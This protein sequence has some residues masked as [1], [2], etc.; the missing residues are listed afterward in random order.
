VEH[1]DEASIEQDAGAAEETL[2]NNQSQCA[3]RGGEEPAAAIGYENNRDE[4]DGEETGRG[5]EEAVAV[6][7][8]KVPGSREPGL[9]R[10]PQEIV[11]VGAGPIGDGH[12]GVV[13]GDKTAD[14]DERKS[15]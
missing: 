3:K 13:G 2:E 8:E 1:G 7:D 5:S 12:A 10:I 11:A 15:D 4:R 9:P 14:P 6:L